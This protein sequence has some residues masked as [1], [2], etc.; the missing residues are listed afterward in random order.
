MPTLE[1]YGY[2]RGERDALIGSLRPLLADL[3]YRADIVFVKAE[4]TEVVAWDGSSRPFVRVLTRRPERAEQI[5]ARINRSCDVETVIIGFYPAIGGIVTQTFESRLVEALDPVRSYVVAACI[6]HLFSTGIYDVLLAGARPAAA[7]AAALDLE[8][9]RAAVFLK[10]LRNEGLLCEQDGGY[11]LS[12][13]GRGLQEFRPW[14]TML[15]G[16]YGKTFLELGDK[17]HRGRGHA[18]RDAAQVGIGS[19]G[20]SHHDAIPL[21]RRLMARAPAGAQRRLLDLGCGNALYLAEF[22]KASPEIEALGVEPSPEGVLAARALIRREGLEHRVR[23]VCSGALEFFAS[24][25]DFTP[26]FV[27]LGFVLHEILGQNGEEAVLDLLRRLVARYPA[28][29]IVVIEVDQRIDD[30]AVM[31]GGLGLAYYN[32]YYLLHPFTDQ[33]LETRAFWDA[34]FDRAGLEIVARGDVDPEVDSTGLELGYLL[35][36]RR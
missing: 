30:P 18:S 22:C 3:P 2:A 14:Y 34:L 17:L 11:A 27:V 28:V 24:P 29:H 19:C 7:I 26:D 12:D 25:S 33:R 13:R 21:T 23:V 15:V 6:Y 9:A 10:F 20:I 16:G 35:R 36:G 8:E 4:P 5:R 31:G 32:A 1:F